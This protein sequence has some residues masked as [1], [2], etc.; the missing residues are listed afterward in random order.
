MRRSPERT[1]GPTRCL[2]A[3][4]TFCAACWARK[5]IMHARKRKEEKGTGRGG[6]CGCVQV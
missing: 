4:P 5:R 2:G 1:V 3:F 6:E